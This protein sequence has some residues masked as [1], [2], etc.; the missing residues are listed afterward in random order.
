MPANARELLRCLVLGRGLKVDGVDCPGAY[1]AWLGSEEVAE[2]LAALD[3]LEAGDPD[4]ADAVEGFHESLTDW[5]AKC[6]DQ[7]CLLLAS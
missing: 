6:S 7:T 2:L 1:Y 5:L 4:V 3:E